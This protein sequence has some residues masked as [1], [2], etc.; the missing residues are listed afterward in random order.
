MTNRFY[1]EAFTAAVGQRAQGSALDNQ[2]ERIEDGF[3]AVADELD[4]LRNPGIITGLE[5]FPASFTGAG[6]KYLV[7]NS[8]ESA[9]EFLAPGYV[10]IN[11]VGGTSYTLVLTDAGKG[12]LTTSSSAVTITIPTNAA[13]AFPVGVSIVV[14]QYG[15]GTVTVTGSVGVTV[16]ATEGLKATRAQFSQ[17][18]LWKVA[19]DQW[20]VG[21]DRA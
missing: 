5:G 10:G 8:A 21:G 6:G 11:S 1:N 4:A 19:T 17:I 7:V 3:D 15:T 12:V 14:V 9:V 2:Y 16:N 13:V 18:T 20:L